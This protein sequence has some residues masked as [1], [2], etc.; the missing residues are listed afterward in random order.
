[1]L[2]RLLLIKSA[3][4]SPIIMMGALICGD[5]WHDGGIHDPQ[6]SIPC[7]RS[8]GSTT[9]IGSV[10]ILR[11]PNAKRA[12][13]VSDV[14]NECFITSHVGTR[15]ISSPRNSSKALLWNNCINLIAATNFCTSA[16]LC[17][18]FSRITGVSLGQ[19]NANRHY[20]CFGDG[21]K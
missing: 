6:S 21:S 13:S 3:A 11:R 15:S 19:A 20:Q 5:R 7:T 14:S 18:Q 2:C 12:A 8:S 1:V 4:F 16:S 10:P 17:R 9:A